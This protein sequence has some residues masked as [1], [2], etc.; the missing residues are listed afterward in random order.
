MRLRSIAA[1]TLAIAV[2]A[3]GALSLGSLRKTT[4]EKSMEAAESAVRRSAALCYALEGAYPQDISYLVSEYGL[5]LNSGE[6]VYHYRYLG[7]NLLP[8]IAVLRVKN[9][10]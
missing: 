6:Y 2:I 7:D 8:E 9:N 3:A 5:R 4:V 1:I 10:G